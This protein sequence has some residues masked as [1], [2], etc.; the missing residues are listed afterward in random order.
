MSAINEIIYQG[1]I[2]IRNPLELFERYNVSDS[3][4]LYFR[5]L[6]NSGQEGKA[7]DEF[8]EHYMVDVCELY[9]ATMQEYMRIA[10]EGELPRT[11]QRRIIKNVA[12]MTV[13]LTGILQINF[14]SFTEDAIAP[15]IFLKQSIKS[16]KVKKAII[17]ATVAQFEEL[18]SGALSETHQFI[19]SGIRRVQ[20][21]LIV[22]NIQIHEMPDISDHIDRAVWNFRK[23][24]KREFPEYF[25]AMERGQI[26]KSR[27]S[28]KDGEKVIHYRL[29]SYADMATRTTILNVDRTA[30]EVVA[31]IENDDFVDYYLRDTRPLKT[32]AER[33]ICKIILRQK[34]K[35]RSILALKPE[36]A[37]RLGI[38][39][40]SEA[41]GQ[42]AMG[43]YCRHSIR[44][45]SNTYKSKI[46]KML[47]KVS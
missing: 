44:R 25:K 4:L 6:I 31:G 1:E 29:E 14:R 37:T 33:E 39:T 21:L 34:I 17:D 12:I 27:R 7:V 46:D 45:V 10:Y 26:L 36:M 23:S 15:S 2:S 11:D 38:M 41:K 35:G 30:V 13:A 9:T 28:G 3:D 20:R 32:G 24:M 40:L 19:V 16:Y 43:P 47:R 42:G 5:S 22:Q 8:V 18:I